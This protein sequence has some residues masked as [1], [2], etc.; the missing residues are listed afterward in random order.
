MAVDYSKYMN[1]PMGEMKR[2][3][4]PKGHYFGR[5]TSHGFKEMGADNKPAY[6]FGFT[7]DS[8]GDDVDVAGLPENGV[9]AKKISLNCMLDFDFGRDAIRETIEAALPGQ[10][11]PTQG[12]GNYLT[13]LDGKPVKLLIEPR[14][15][16]KND[17][18]PDPEMTDDI[19][20][21]LP[22]I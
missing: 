22:A 17:T 12:W 16:D 15:R 21:V 3:V 5:I 20:K 4:L 1:T 9:A 11:D 13:Q 6:V 10:T 19:K 7:L 2:T 8:A 18:S 14:K